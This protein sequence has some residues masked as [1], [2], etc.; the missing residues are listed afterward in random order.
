MSESEVVRR[1]ASQV[2]AIAYALDQGLS[3]GQPFFQAND[4]SKEAWADAKSRELGRCNANHG[5]RSER[6]RD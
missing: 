4:I 5:A 2:E 1:F 3:W 6:R